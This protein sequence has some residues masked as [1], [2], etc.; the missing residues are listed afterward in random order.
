MTGSFGGEGGEFL[1][2]FGSVEDHLNRRMKIKAKIAKT[3]GCSKKDVT[4]G[5]R[6]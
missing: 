3:M 2:L 6:N 1:L 5:P 4:F